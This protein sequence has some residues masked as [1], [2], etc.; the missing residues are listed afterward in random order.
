GYGPLGGAQAP[1]P[2]AFTVILWTFG[3]M[4]FF[5]TST[6]YVAQL[7]PPGR[8]GEYMGAFA[9]TFS[10]AQIVGPWL[11]AML[12]DRIGAPSTWATM[13]AI[14]LVAAGMTGLT[15]SQATDAVAAE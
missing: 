12:L 13:L 2:I 6:A 4:I 3:E 9:S 5:P 14:G 11:G 7:A 8:T 1:L 10:L 15:Q